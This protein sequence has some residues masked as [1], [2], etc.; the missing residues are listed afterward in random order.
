PLLDLHRL[1]DD[2]PEIETVLRPGELIT[3]VELAPSPAAANSAYRK[4]RDR[5]SYAFALV[6]VAAGVAVAGGRIQD[7][8]IA[9]GGVA[10]KPWRA[11]RA[12]EVL[13]GQA[14]AKAHFLAAAD[15]ELAV[16]KTFNGNAF[17]V[18]LAKRTIAAVLG[19]LTGAE[20]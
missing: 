1:P 20:A 18:E 12:E 14:P 13:R 11:M 15:A 8:R 5:S 4:V 2:H 3:A 6:S 19:E 17:K 10:P 9:L 7:V 16:A